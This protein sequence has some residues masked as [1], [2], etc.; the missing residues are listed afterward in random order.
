[1]YEMGISIC[2]RLNIVGLKNARLFAIT[3]QTS[4]REHYTFF[5]KTRPFGRSE[6][7][8]DHEELCCWSKG[9]IDLA[10]GVWL[11]QLIECD[12]S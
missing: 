7:L 10:P 3:C 6:L 2:C 8:R 12:S 5:S 9:E 1:M 11:R 4:S